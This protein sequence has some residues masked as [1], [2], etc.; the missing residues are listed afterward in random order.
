MKIAIMLRHL[1][2]KGGVVVY[3]RNLLAALFKLDRQNEYFLLHRSESNFGYFAPS[4]NVTEVALQA[5]SK[6]LWDQFVVPRYLKTEHIDL[7]FN[8]RHSIP[9]YTQAKKV[10]VMHGAEQF[11]VPSAFKPVDRIYFTFAN[12]RYCSAADAVITMTE[13]G[14]RDIVRYMGADPAKINVIPEAYN[15]LCRVL[16]ESSVN[17]V[18]GQ[19]ALPDRFALFIGGL[20]PLKNLGRTLKAFSQL[21]VGLRH[22]VVLGFKRWKF[23][24]DLDLVRELNLE[25]RVH[26]VGFVPDEDLPAFYNRAEVLLFPSLYEGFGIPTLEAMACGCPVVA[27]M[28]GCSP[29]VAGGGAEL[30]DPYDVESIRVGTERVLRDESLRQSMIVKGLQRCK[31]FSWNKTAAATLELFESILGSWRTCSHSATMPKTA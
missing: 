4:V 21:N 22:L 11:A 23:Q 18:L 17:A 30:V 9:L 5:S 14:K 26:F 7:V 16:P 20:L 2:D 19:Y 13:T 31:D 15:E 27:S 29:E 12:P 28:A 3:T 6:P 25:K 10:F 24:K 1:S 8:P